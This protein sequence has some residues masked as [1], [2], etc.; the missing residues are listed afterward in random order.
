MS[1]L[2]I[3]MPAYNEEANI[4]NVINQWYPVVQKVNKQ[5]DNCHLVIANDGSRDNTFT[6]LLEA[7][8]EYPL[9][10]PLDKR[11]TGHGSTVLFLYRYALD[12]GADFIF[13]TD[14]DGQ[15]NP[16]EFFQMWKNRDEFDF[17]IGQRVKRQDG[18]SRVIVTN[19]LKLVVL[20]IF[21]VWVKD[22]NTPF[23]LMESN[24]LRQMLKYVPDDFFLANVAISAL[25]VKSKLKVG[26][27]PINF[28]PR[29]G[30]K[31]S[32]NLKRIVIIG[33]KALRDLKNVNN[34]MSIIQ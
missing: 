21:R 34:T 17:H 13:Q 30:G 9:L 3:V 19:V 31:N 24:K 11:N 2:F 22:A 8:K 7:S 33:M 6:L 5:G 20:S 16:E 12:N 32:I 10:I 14:S 18:I 29:Q 26:W 27:Y 25:A 15:T 28:K 23:R 1:S 4:K